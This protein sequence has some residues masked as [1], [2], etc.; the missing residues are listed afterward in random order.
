MIRY[1]IID[2]TNL[3]IG[4]GEAQNEFEAGAAGS[5]LGTV[6]VIPD[7]VTVVAGEYFWTGSTF[8][9]LPPKP[10]EWLEWDGT[11]WADPRDPAQIA[12]DL[13][14]A[15]Y[16]TNTDKNLVFYRLAGEGAYPASELADDTTYFPA[17]VEAYLSTLA[18]SEHDQVKAALKYEPLIWRLHPYLIG[19]TGIVGFVPWLLAEHS[20]TITDAQLDTIFEV[21][22]PP[23][24]Y[25]AP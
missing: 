17:T 18:P 11:E 13:H 3:V 24:L 22:V 10:E 1:A 19:D 14:Q 6:E 23:P 15:R 20:I 4:V 2:A 7:G 21:P 8:A 25:T 9:E 5:E 12:V 16:Q